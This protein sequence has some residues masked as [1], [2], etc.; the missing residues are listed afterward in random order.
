MQFDV[1]LNVG[2]IIK[3][4]RGRLRMSQ[5]EFARRANLSRN[6]ISIIERGNVKVEDIP[7]ST[8]QGIFE[9]MGAEMHIE[10]KPLKQDDITEV[11]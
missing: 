9:A 10:I 5:A 6:Y 11:K 7:L 2:E 8:L 1:T 3:I 4:F